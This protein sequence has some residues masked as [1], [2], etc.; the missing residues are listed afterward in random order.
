MWDF[1]A[2]PFPFASV[3]LAHQVVPAYPAY[4]ALFVVVALRHAQRVGEV[5]DSVDVFGGG[6]SLAPFE[7]FVEGFGVVVPGVSL[8][9]G[10]TSGHGVCGMARLSKRSFVAVLVF[11]STAMVTVYIARHGIGG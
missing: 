4:A 6:A 10:C 3:L 1:S 11:L 2:V 5:E 7:G 9:N 8:A